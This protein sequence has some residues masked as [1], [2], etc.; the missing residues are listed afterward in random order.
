MVENNMKYKVAI[1]ILGLAIVQMAIFVF[2][3]LNIRLYERLDI[4]G[5]NKISLQSMVVI[6]FLLFILC[7]FHYMKMKENGVNFGLSRI[8]GISFIT[9]ATLAMILFIWVRFSEEKCALQIQIDIESSQYL[10]TNHEE[11]NT[12]MIE[13]EYSM[14]DEFYERKKEIINQVEN[15]NPIERYISLLVYNPGYDYYSNVVTHV[16]E[17]EYY[18][19]Y[20][21]MFLLGIALSIFYLKNSHSDNE[22]RNTTQ[23]YYEE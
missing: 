13:T 17:I 11:L 15:S 9:Y 12:A 1:G 22:T 19:I 8:I 3:S 16:S 7:M 10:Y 14:N 2:I 18:V 21:E 4:T 23:I 6:L 20:L 5:M